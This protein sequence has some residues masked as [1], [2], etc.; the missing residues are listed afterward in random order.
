MWSRKQSAERKSEREYALL[1]PRQIRMRNRLRAGR[2]K[3]NTSASPFSGIAAQSERSLTRPKSWLVFHENKISNLRPYQMTE[4]S[5]CS[6]SD[7]HVE[8]SRTNARAVWELHNWVSPFPRWQAKHNILY[9]GGNS[10]HIR[11]SIS[12]F[13]LRRP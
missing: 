6:N 3:G 5:L 7:V 10:W 1:F 12:I 9:P 8:G 11:I 2:W 13:R 4:G